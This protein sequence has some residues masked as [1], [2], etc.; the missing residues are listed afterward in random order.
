[1][2]APWGSTPRS[3]PVASQG[4]VSGGCSEGL[5]CWGGLLGHT[6]AASLAAPAAQCPGQGPS[7]SF[8]AE[9][10]RSGPSATASGGEGG[11]KGGEGEFWGVAKSSPGSHFS[12][13]TLRLGRVW[14]PLALIKSIS[15]ALGNEINA[16][17]TLTPALAP[18]VWRCGRGHGRTE[19]TRHRAA[20]SRCKATG[21]RAQP[22][23]A[24]PTLPGHADSGLS[25]LPRSWLRGSCLHPGGLGS[26]PRGHFPPQHRHPVPHPL[27]PTH[28]NF[29]PRPRAEPSGPQQRGEPAPAVCTWSET[30]ILM[31]LLLFLRKLTV[32]SADEPF[33]CVGREQ[34]P[35][36]APGSIG[37]ATDARS[38]LS[39]A[40]KRG[41]HAGVR[42]NQSK[43]GSH[44]SFVGSHFE[45]MP[46][47]GPD[48]SP[49]PI[50]PRVPGCW[51]VHLRQ[52]HC[53]IPG[54]AQTT[55]SHHQKNTG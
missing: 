4:C 2:G 38:S 26:A 16:L 34:T 49:R 14:N 21:R 7:G 15:Q 33:P 41:A 10:R 53:I 32:L 18:R 8:R 13:Q 43:P 39:R 25:H 31:H 24:A 1:M 40:G 9:N 54:T 51:V 5:R 12:S 29:H 45:E 22:A 28:G 35:S 30:P 48:L 17:Q 27:P 42:Q 20:I 44:G 19:H 50:A 36:P 37:H 3:S 52:E 46:Q 23:P 6:H 55:F 11:D 47:R